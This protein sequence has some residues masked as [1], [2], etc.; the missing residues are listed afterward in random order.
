MNKIEAWEVQLKT[1]IQYVYIRGNY[2][3][4]PQLVL[5]IEDTLHHSP[6]LYVI[7]YVAE[8]RKRLE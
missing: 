7:G 5:K 2:L 6:I 1:S 4:R 3:K 8:E